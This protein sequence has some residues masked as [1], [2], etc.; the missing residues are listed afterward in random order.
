M[1]AVFLLLL[2]I[3]LFRVLIGPSNED[4]MLGIQL[5]AT[6]GVSTLC[7]ESIAYNNSALIDASLVLALLSPIA[8]VIFVTLQGN[9]P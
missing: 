4:R 5:F 3:G 1:E 9:R 8:I 2:M 7:V 6:I